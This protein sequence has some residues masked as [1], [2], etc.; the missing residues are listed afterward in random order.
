M[1]FYWLIVA[2][3]RVAWLLRPPTA[4]DVARID[5]AARCPTCGYAGERSTIRCVLRPTGEGKVVTGHTVFVEHTCGADGA[6]WFEAPVRK[7]DRT[8]VWPAIPRTEIERR[9]DTEISLANL[10]AI[11]EPEAPKAKTN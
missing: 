6:R 3:R 8:R 2:F 11:P 1:L 4:L 10:A 9:E 5:P 7:V